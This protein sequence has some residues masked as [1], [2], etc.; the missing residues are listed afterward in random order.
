M[1][2]QPRRPSVGLCLALFILF[3]QS[4]ISVFWFSHVRP[5]GGMWPIVLL[6]FGLMNV[7]YAKFSL[8]MIRRFG[9]DQGHVILATALLALTLFSL[10]NF[11]R[12]FGPA[13]LVASTNLQPGVLG[14]D[15]TIYA[16]YVI[17]A[18]LPIGAKCQ[19]IASGKRVE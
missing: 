12:L 15:V 13:G 18:L 10:H 14:N 2:P 1:T 6:I 4:A 9:V 17:F 19:H 3:L 7:A 8:T 5:D 11:A 16:L